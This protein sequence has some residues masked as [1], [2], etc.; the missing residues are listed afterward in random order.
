MLLHKLVF[1]QE[2]SLLEDLIEYVYTGKNCKL[3]FLGDTAQLPPVN[4]DLSPAL[5]VELLS[6]QYNFTIRSIEFDEVMR[7][8]ETSGVLFNATQLRERLEEDFYE[9]F[10]FS[11]K[12]FKDIIRLTDSYDIQE[13]IHSAYGITALKTLP[14]S[15]GLTSV[16]ISTTSKLECA[17]WIRKMNSRQVII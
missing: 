17:F 2:Q 5:D 16:P 13:A 12:P 15:C 9:D 11:L 7:Q 4:S 3:L 10:R 14:L 8:A 1:Q 6:K